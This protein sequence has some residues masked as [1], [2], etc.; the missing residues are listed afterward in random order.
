MHYYQAFGLSIK[1]EIELP[2]LLAKPKSTST[3]VVIN[4]ANIALPNYSEDFSFKHCQLI[5]NKLCLD[6]PDVARF[7]ISS[8]KII[9]DI[10]K[11]ADIQTVRLYLLG[12]GLG[13]LML[14]R[15]KLLLHGNA[16]N[17]N[18]KGVVVVA[19]SGVGKST[20][21]AEFFKR[22]HSL[23]A[24]D[25]CSIGTSRNIYPSYPYIKIWKNSI[26]SLNLPDEDL[27]KIR[28]HNDKFYY[29]LRQLFQPTEL[30]LSSIY[31]LNKA[32]IIELKKRKISGIEKIQRLKNH[33]YRPLYSKRLGIHRQLILKL[34]Q[35]AQEVPVT[36]ITRPIDH[37]SAPE[38]ADMI[39]KAEVNN[40]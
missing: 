19:N 11:S 12:S 14:Q 26:I 1:S 40:K 21:A 35:I 27:E 39:I 3:D 38:I 18:G 28:E 16:I 17:I 2:K 33:F 9:I 10:N 15:D 8:N 30:K 20:L 25:V 29:P 36:H 4:L 7:L 5:D 22:G 13:A 6:I 23:L 24:D 34:S 37:F 32:K 31:I